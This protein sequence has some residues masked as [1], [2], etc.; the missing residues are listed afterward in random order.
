MGNAAMCHGVNKIQKK[1][2]TPGFRKSEFRIRVFRIQ[3]RETGFQNREIGILKIG[4]WTG[5]L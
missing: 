4:N 2:E 3:N 5:K 1:L